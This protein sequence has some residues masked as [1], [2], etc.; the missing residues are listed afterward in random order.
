MTAGLLLTAAP[1]HVSAL[2]QDTAL[3]SELAEPRYSY[4]TLNVAALDISSWGKA[5]CEGSYTTY[6]ENVTG[7]LTIKLQKRN[8][9]GTWSTQET[10]SQEYKGSG[11]HGF[12][13]T[14]KVNG[15]GSY[16]TYLD[17][18]LKVNGKVVETATNYSPTW[19]Y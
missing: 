16:R 3:I 17:L 2:N 12:T 7:T 1:L 11:F 14:I 5:T 18:V 10:W 19:D 9:D 15:H 6:E 13:E 4:H 8:S